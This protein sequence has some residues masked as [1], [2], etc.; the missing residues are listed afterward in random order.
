MDSRSIRDRFDLT[1]KTAL[2]TGASRG[3]G[4]AIARGLAEFGA[5]VMVSSRKQEAVEAVAAAL[6]KEGRQAAAMAAHMGDPQA[7]QAL[8]DATLARWGRI[9]IAVNNAAVN[10]VF[11]PIEATDGAAFDKIMAVNVKGP[12]ELARRLLPAMRQAKGGSIVNI[13]S[14]GGLRPEPM[15]GLYSVSKA[16]LVML[17]KVLAQEGGDA[18]IRVN[19]ICPGL[20]QTRFSAALWQDQAILEG[21]LAR[22]PLGRIAQPEEIVPLVLYLASDASSYATGGVYALDGG[23]TI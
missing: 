20:V 17:T 23:Y 22:V 1:G 13:A 3:I 9:D 4:E 2:V 12:F 16:A 7:V 14:T 18:G 5:Q 21:F 8:V 19:C 10:P 15:L 11:G 6:V